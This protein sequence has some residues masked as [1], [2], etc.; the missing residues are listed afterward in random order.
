MISCSSTL[1]SS[2]PATSAKVTLGVSPVRSFAFDLPNENALLPPPCIWRRKK[3]QKPKITI[4]G[5]RFTSSA[6]IDGLGSCASTTTPFS[7]SRSSSLSEFETGSLTLN[8]RTERLLIITGDLKVPW[9]TLPPMTVTCWMLSACSCRPYSV[10]FTSLAPSERPPAYWMMNTGT[11]MT[12][13]QKA[14]VLERRPNLVG[15]VGVCGV[16]DISGLKDGLGLGRRGGAPNSAYR[17]A[18]LATYGT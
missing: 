12:I 1:A 16:L 13:S 9:M 10:Y 5:S 18:R 3:I 6:P 7:L 15:G 14:M 17:Q 8:F 11:R 4:Q 2:Q